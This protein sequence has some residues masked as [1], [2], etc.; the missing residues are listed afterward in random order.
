MKLIAAAVL[1]VALVAAPAFAKE[2]K[3]VKLADTTT[4]EGQELKLTGAGVRNKWFFDVYVIGLYVADPAKD[5]LSDQAKQVNLT[6]LRDLDKGKLSDAI[7]EGFER[8]SSAQMPKLK[9]RL[10]KLVGVLADGK[11]NDSLVLSY[12][13]GKGTIVAAKGKQLTTI[14]GDDFG[15]A[16]FSVWLGKVPADADLKKEMLGQK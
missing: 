9:D 13:P 3:G 2:L 8:N 4:V 12:V 16:L 6:L 11:K 1:S 7:R 15:K 10:D 14:E 5:V